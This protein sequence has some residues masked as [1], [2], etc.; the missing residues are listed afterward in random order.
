MQLRHILAAAD[1]SDEGRA[2][3]VGALALARARVARVTVLRVTAPPEDPL[4]TQRQVDQ[5][6]ATIRKLQPLHA[7]AGRIDA[8]VVT[9]LPG[10]EI[11][12]FAERMRADLV[13][14]GR[15]Q[16]TEAERQLRGDTADAVARRSPVPCLLVPTVEQRFDRILGALDGTERGMYVL[17]TAI[18]FARATGA[19]LSLVSVEPGGSADAAADGVPTARIARLQ[20][21]VRDLRSGSDLGAGQWAGDSGLS[22]PPVTVCRGPVVAEVL[23]QAEIERADVL[24]IGY[25]RGGPAGP[26]DSSDICRR[27]AREAPCAVLTVPL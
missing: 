4:E 2:A 1:D 14:V 21:V 19:Q 20:E 13:V 24:V 27:L 6:R 22:T 17:R 12:R 16:R 5:L 25:R 18:D 3:I 23:H 8:T 7:V 15:K 9:G 10:I 11:G 26:V